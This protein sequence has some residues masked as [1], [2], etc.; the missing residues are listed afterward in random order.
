MSW[1]NTG[2]KDDVTGDKPADIA[3]SALQRILRE[4]KSRSKE[5]PALA[6]LLRAIGVVAT[7]MAE[8]NL[9]GQTAGPPQLFAALKSGERV[10][11][12]P[13]RVDARSEDLIEPL[14]E[15]LRAMAEAYQ[16]RWERRPRLSE[17]LNAFEFV[18]RYRPEEFLEDGLKHQPAKIKFE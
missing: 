17:W 16:E 1:W 9:D 2:N 15:G 12:G 8:K 6:D 11:S 10:A 3:R 14:T 18:L 5:K 4:R 13:L 7:G